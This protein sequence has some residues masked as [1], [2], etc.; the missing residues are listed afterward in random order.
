MTND[1][2]KIFK[3]EEFE[4]IDEEY[5][6]GASSVVLLKKIIET[7][8]I[9]ALKKYLEYDNMEFI[10]GEII[11]EILFLKQL[12]NFSCIIDIYGVMFLDNEFYIVLEYID[13]NLKD[14]FEVL[15]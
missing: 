4:D 7:G 1:N 12:S 10:D 2:F 13:F 9:V 15:R 8:K 3:P 6:D 14:Y 11:G 5:G